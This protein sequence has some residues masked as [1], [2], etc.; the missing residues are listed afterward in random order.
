MISDLAINLI[1]EAFMFAMG[2]YQPLHFNFELTLVDTVE[3]FLSFIFFILPIKSMLNVL[4]IIIAVI[5]FR[6]LIAFVTTI[7]RLLPFT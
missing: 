4:P 6:I 3:D 2:G 5:G 7:W 1:Y